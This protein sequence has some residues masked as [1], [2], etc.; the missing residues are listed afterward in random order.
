MYTYKIKA[1]K[2]SGRLNEAAGKMPKVLTYTS[3]SKL[4]EHTVFNKALKYIR[5][6]YGVILEMADITGGNTLQN[7]EKLA[8][9]IARRAIKI[10]YN[11]WAE[12]HGSPE[13]QGRELTFLDCIEQTF[14]S[15]Y[16]DEIDCDRDEAKEIM[17][18]CPRMQKEALKWLRKIK[19]NAKRY[20]RPWD[21]ADDAALERKAAKYGMPWN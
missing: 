6:K 21:S 3:V 7:E 13:E 11:E 14:M 4:N 17:Y 8:D 10:V 12:Y 2:L 5:S 1:L 20:R 9:K 16:R 18:A 19:R 15:M